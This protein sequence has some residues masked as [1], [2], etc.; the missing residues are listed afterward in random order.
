MYHAKHPEG[1]RTNTGG[2]SFLGF[3]E[4]SDEEEINNDPEMNL[5]QRL[6]NNTAKDS[7]PIR[8]DELLDGLP[9]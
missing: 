9:L 8:Q 5:R 2:G 7:R 1:K 3:D 6:V 4:D